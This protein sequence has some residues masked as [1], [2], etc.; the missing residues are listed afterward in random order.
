MYLSRLLLG[1][2]SSSPLLPSGHP[3][4]FAQAKMRAKDLPDRLQQP[5]T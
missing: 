2:A 1:E 4:L 5:R 3:F